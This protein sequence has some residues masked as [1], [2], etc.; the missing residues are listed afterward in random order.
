MSLAEVEA[1][2]RPSI[3]L[4][5]LECF[6]WTPE[7]FPVLKNLSSP[8]CLNDRITKQCNLVRLR[9]RFYFAYNEAVEFLF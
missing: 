5:R 4:S 2:K 9:C 6:T 8:L 3:S 7:V 1:F